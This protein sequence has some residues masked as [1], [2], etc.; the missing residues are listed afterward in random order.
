MR[1]ATYFLFVVASLIL[2]AIVSD[3]LP[4]YRFERKPFRTLSKRKTNKNLVF[5]KRYDRDFS[6]TDQ[7]VFHPA[8]PRKRV[9]KRSEQQSYTLD[10]HASLLQ[11][12]DSVKSNAPSVHKELSSKSVLTPDKYFQFDFECTAND[13]SLCPKAKEA[14]ESAGTRIAK[15]LKLYKPIKVLAKYNSFCKLTCE[16]QTLGRAGAASFWAMKNDDGREIL[17]PQALTKQLSEDQLDYAQYDI[18]AEFNADKWKSLPEGVD[19]FWFKV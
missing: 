15:V 8:T 6:K 17:Y 12:S 13:E 16:D 3:A 18:V 19:K 4:V 2:F 5:S 11:A 14:F 7:I 9:K 10:Q 1:F